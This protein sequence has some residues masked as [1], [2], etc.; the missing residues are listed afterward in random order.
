MPF[1][2]RLGYFLIGLSIGLIFLTLF[3]KKKTDETGTEFCYLPNCRVLKELRSKPLRVDTALKVATDS[4]LIQYL[5]RE[6]DVD[7]SQSDT[8][9]K[10]CKIYSISGSAGEEKLR[11]TIENCDS[12]TLLTSYELEP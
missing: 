4:L 11:I 9:A 3:L 8:R 10:P 7:F 6:G 5:L 1:L 12:Y 2:K